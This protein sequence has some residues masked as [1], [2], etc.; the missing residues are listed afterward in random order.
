[1]TEADIYLPLSGLAGGQVYPYVAPLSPDGNVSISPPWLVFSLPQENSADVFCGAAESMTTIQ[2]D[3]YSLK[4]DEAREIRRLA[5]NAL[6]P[7][8]IT[9]IRKYQDYEPD[10]RLYRSTFEASVTW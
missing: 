4:V 3:V 5:I 2:I 8:G 10:T 7:A 1:M 9:E 6:T